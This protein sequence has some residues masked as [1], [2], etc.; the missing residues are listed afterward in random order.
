MPTQPPTEKV[1]DLLQQANI[2][3]SSVRPDGR[4]HMVPVWFV[5]HEERIYIGID[6]ASVKSRNIRDNPGVVLALEDGSHPLICEGAARIVNPPL[7][8]LL[9]AAFMKKYEWDLTS[10]A[11][12]HQVVEVTPKKWLSW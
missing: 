10:E 6:P 8:E 3:F 7:P 12:F 9:L 11:Q 5:Y 1:P 4:P 2:W